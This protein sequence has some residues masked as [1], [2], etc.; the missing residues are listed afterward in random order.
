MGNGNAPNNNPRQA[1]SQPLTDAEFQQRRQ[2]LSEQIDKADDN[3]EEAKK[4]DGLQKAIDARL[5]SITEAEDK[6]K[7][8]SAEADRMQN[9]ADEKQQIK[10]L[11]EKAKEQK[12]KLSKHRD[13]DL[14]VNNVIV[15][16]TIDKTLSIFDR[17]GREVKALWS[18]V[19]DNMGD[20]TIWLAKQ[21][22]V[23]SWF[24]SIELRKKMEPKIKHFNEILLANTNATLATPKWNKENADIVD[25]IEGVETY[26]AAPERKLDFGVALKAEIGLGEITIQQLLEAAKQAKAKVV[27]APEQAQ[28]TI[29]EKGMEL[30]KTE[31]YTKK[32]T[33]DGHDVYGHQDE[34][35]DPAKAA[36]ATVFYHDSAKGWQ[37]A[38]MNGTWGKVPNGK[39]NDANPQHQR[40]DAL[41]EKLSKLT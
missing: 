16:T 40:A 5:K 21:F 9:N 22:G 27:Q 17:V 4:Q 39:W 26:F 2:E 12:E 20:L 18:K 3:I 7:N 36:A 11:E 34:L 35:D 41:A 10:E 28:K 37:W 33:K 30:L 8:L 19:S 24:P 32:T 25:A 13:S 1:P 38:S 15:G 23:E 6:L 14:L 31:G 29:E